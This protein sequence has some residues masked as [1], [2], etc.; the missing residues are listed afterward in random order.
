MYS[1]IQVFKTISWLDYNTIGLI[2]SRFVGFF[3][4]PLLSSTP[5]SEIRWKPFLSRNSVET[6]FIQKFVRSKNDRSQTIGSLHSLAHNTKRNSFNP[7]MSTPGDCYLDIWCVVCIAT[8]DIECVCVC[9]CVFVEEGKREKR[10][11]RDT[12]SKISPK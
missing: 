7:S 11:W 8:I 1:A 3:K 5:F 4:H 9:V 6:L 12:I 10:T 2:S